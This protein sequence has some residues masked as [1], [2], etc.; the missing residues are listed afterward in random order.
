MICCAADLMNAALPHVQQARRLIADLDV[1]AQPLQGHS[2]LPQEAAASLNSDQQTAVQRYGQASLE[3]L[4][5]ETGSACA[6]STTVIISKLTGQI[7]HAPML[8]NI[9][10]A[11]TVI[12]QMPSMQGLMLRV[13]STADYSAS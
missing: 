4:T 1:P 6:I 10:S 8:L 9:G 7:G 3:T 5:P 13:V 11:H 12:L 2:N